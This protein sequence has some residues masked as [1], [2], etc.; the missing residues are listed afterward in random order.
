GEAVFAGFSRA[1]DAV[2][3]AEEAQRS[4]AT[5]VGM[6]L[7]TGEPQVTAEGYVGMDVHRAARICAAA[8]GRQVVLSGPTRDLVTNCHLPFRDLGEH[9]LKD[10]SEPV[11]LYQLGD[12][13]FPPL[14]TLFATNLPVPATPFLGRPRELGDLV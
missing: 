3:A 7:H 11:R 14:R 6:G 13:D 2:D 5:P 9:R 1:S 10:L 4:L 12:G 8:H